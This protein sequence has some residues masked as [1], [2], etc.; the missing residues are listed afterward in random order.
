MS[1]RRL[2]LVVALAI[3]LAALLLPA[4]TDPSV[5]GRSPVGADTLAGDLPHGDAAVLGARTSEQR[6]TWSDRSP[7]R[8]FMLLAVAAAMLLCGL[9]H[10]RAT[11]GNPVGR[12]QVFSW[13][14]QSG[15][16]PPS[17]VS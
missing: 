3:A 6:D 4:L 10:R 16:A 15:R 14:P 12:R 1:R 9:A 7:K 17:F 2:H 11:R 13:T 8:I 5:P